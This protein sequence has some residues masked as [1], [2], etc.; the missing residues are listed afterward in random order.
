[1][2]PIAI[3]LIFVVFV[4]GPLFA[5]GYIWLDRRISRR[6]GANRFRLTPVGNFFLVVFV[7]TAGIAIV[8]RQFYPETE[9]GTWL[10]TEGVMPSFVIGCLAVLFAIEAFLKWLDHP[11]AKDKA[12]QSRRP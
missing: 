1:M 12:T 7:A 8:V 10:K 11:T 6:T 3:Y 2:D 9:L 5:A 4:F